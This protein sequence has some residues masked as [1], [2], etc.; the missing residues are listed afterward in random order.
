MTKKV[1]VVTGATGGLGSAACDKM[2]EKYI[3]VVSDIHE[4]KINAKVKELRD[5][6]FEAFG[7]ICD[8][9]DRAQCFELARFASGLG[10]VQGV[11]Q[12]AGL[13]PAFCKYTDL[14]DVDVI[15]TININEAFFNVMEKGSSII[16]ICSCVAHFMPEETWPVDIFEIALTDRQKFRDAFVE[17]ISIF[18]D[19]EACSNMAYV[20]GRTFIKWFAGKSAYAFGRKKGIRINTVS[21]GFVVTEQSMADLDAAGGDAEGRLA[22]QMSYSAF[23]RASTPDELAFL[24]DALIDER[25]SWFSGTD[26]Y[27]DNGCSANGYLG[28]FEPYDP[29]VNPY[30]P[31]REYIA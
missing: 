1:C 12:L 22:Q 3:V 6:G 10:P 11:I 4:D 24:F 2:A 27:Y 25:N 20:Y 7:K 28:Q 15:G 9:S 5:K 31:S 26:I 8:T 18:G 13:T 17:Y 29:S 30:D 16:D 14:I 21:V 23:G 19:D